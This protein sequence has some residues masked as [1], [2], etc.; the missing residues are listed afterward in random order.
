MFASS[1]KTQI[2]E[3]RFSEIQLLIKPKTHPQIQANKAVERRRLVVGQNKM[4]LLKVSRPFIDRLAFGK[5]GKIDLKNTKDH[6]MSRFGL[7]KEGT[8]S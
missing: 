5:L 2:L 6:H 8:Y 7:F 3:S 1:H 4:C